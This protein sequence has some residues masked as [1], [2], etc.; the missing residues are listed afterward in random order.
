[1]SE[2]V[3]SLPLPHDRVLAEWAATLNEAG[4]WAYMFDAS[5][6]LVFATDELRLSFGD[7][8][9]DTVLP[10]GS[11][12]FSAEYLRYAASVA[13]G[14][15]ALSEFRRAWFSGLGPYMLTTMP[16]GRE[17][18]RR[19]VDP[20][21]VDLID[22]LQPRDVPDAW[23][24]PTPASSTFAGVE[25]AGLVSWFRIDDRHGNLAGFRGCRSLPRRPTP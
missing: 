1:M 2:S 14:L 23:P 9:A 3:E 15:N 24:G 6:R 13:G 7:T 16:G 20:E 10:I 22:E 19:V 25:V 12:L 17:E 4:H 21:L 8:G 11:R 5:W 18:L